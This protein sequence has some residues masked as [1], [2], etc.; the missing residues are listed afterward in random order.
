[1]TKGPVYFSMDDA[2]EDRLAVARH[3]MKTAERQRRDMQSQ[4]FGGIGI[5][6]LIGATVFGVFGWWGV[7]AFVA[8]CLVIAYSFA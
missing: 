7:A 2:T 4:L 3:A 1:M 6:A 8:V 5:G